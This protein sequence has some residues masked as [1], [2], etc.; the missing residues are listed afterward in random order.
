MKT[1]CIWPH[2]KLANFISIAHACSVQGK[3][4]ALRKKLELLLYL[5][6]NKINNEH[7]DT[8]V[9]HDSS[10]LAQVYKSQALNKTLDSKADS[11]IVQLDL[12]RVAMHGLSL[13]LPFT[14]IGFYLLFP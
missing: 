2:L 14:L 8:M 12:L 11:K 3:P 4:C 1:Q 9:I 13:L 10:R 5:V 6:N 7:C